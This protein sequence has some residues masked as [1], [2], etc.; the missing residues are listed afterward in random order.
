LVELMVVITIIGILAGVAVPRF[1][2]FRA[3]SQQSE[4]KSGLNGLY[5]AMQSYEANYGQFCVSTATS[6]N[7]TAA[8][9]CNPAAAVG[10]ATVYNPDGIFAIGF[11]MGGNQ[12]RYTYQM[13]SG[14]RAWAAT[15]ASQTTLISGRDHLRINTNK[16]TCSRWDAVTGTPAAAP[17]AATTQT[18]TSPTQC[19]N[20]IAAAP[21]APAATALVGGDCV[22]G[23]G[24]A[25][26]ACA[27]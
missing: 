21:A 10:V 13:Q 16:W 11:R 6:H 17:P 27:L 7:S 15:A 26:P 9:A 22:M 12:N 4:A 18:A 1:Q 5:L 14:P 19:H 23:V 25:L 24:T 3:R 20:A 2:T 8:A